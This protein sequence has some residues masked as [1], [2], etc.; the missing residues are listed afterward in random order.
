M[1]DKIWYRD[2]DT[3]QLVSV[4]EKHPQSKILEKASPITVTLVRVVVGQDYDTFGRH[5]DLFIM[6]RSG[7]GTKRPNVDRF[8]AY[9]KEVP[10]DK[11]V[12]GMYNKI[13]FVKDD[14]NGEDRLWLELHVRE[15]DIQDEDIDKAVE[16]FQ[17]MASTA[18]A[19]FPVALPYMFGA[20][21]AASLAGKLLG[22]LIKDTRAMDVEFDLNSGDPEVGQMV[23]QTGTYVVFNK[24]RNGSLFSLEQNGNLLKNGQ[25]VQDVTYAV[26]TIVDKKKFEPEEELSQR[27][28]T[29]LTQMK[30]DADKPEG[31]VKAF[32]FLTDTMTKYDQFKKLDRYFD[33][34]NRTDP[35]LSE[36]EKALMNNIAAINEL[37]PFLPTS[38]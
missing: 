20:S 1:G 32:Y 3:K 36:K 4:F 5:N 33:L 10:K 13:M 18:G 22:W 12:P 27:I 37:A 15:V 24:E 30:Q 23:L 28:S 29:L 26:I 16:L 9:K 2:P 25:P 38:T 19:V 21:A 11:P 35:P 14:Y 34:Y 31:L 6:S 17:K 8:H 7:M